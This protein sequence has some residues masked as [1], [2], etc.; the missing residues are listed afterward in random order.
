MI[1]S[2]AV[3]RYR[4]ILEWELQSRGKA[5][6]EA[7][8]ELSRLNHTQSRLAIEIGR[9][10]V[11]SQT[12]TSVEAIYACIRYHEKKKVEMSRLEEEEIQLKTRIYELELAF[13]EVWRRKE[14]LTRLLAR[15]AR[16]LKRTIALTLSRE[17]GDL[18]MAGQPPPQ[19]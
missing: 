8:S 4:E 1:K 5:V 2:A 10:A 17:E 3:E 19:R 15:Q 13:S 9:L 7:R 18:I 14:A 16:R 12:D 11:I 6:A